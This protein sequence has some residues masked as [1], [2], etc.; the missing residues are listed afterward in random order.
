MNKMTVTP[1]FGNQNQRNNGPVNAHLISE[2]VIGTNLATND[3]RIFA[4]I[5][6]LLWNLND[7]RPRSRTPHITSFTHIQAAIIS[8]ESIIVTIFYIT[9]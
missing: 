2:P 3:Q 8:K 6:L 1:I 9:A 7:V 4:C 5:K